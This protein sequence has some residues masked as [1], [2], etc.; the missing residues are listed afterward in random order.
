ML[1][2]NREQMLGVG[3]VLPV[4]VAV[5]LIVKQVRSLVE[6]AL[7]LVASEGDWRLAGI[8]VENATQDFSFGTIRLM[9]LLLQL[10]IR[11]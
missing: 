9:Y 10:C 8:S 11:L 5:M 7:M 4:A 3:T 2:S 6:T 1:V